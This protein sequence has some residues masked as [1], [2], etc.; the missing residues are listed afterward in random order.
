MELLLQRPAAGI[1]LEYIG[2]ALVGALRRDDQSGAGVHQ[3]V[4]VRVRV[5]HAVTARQQPLLFRP[6]VVE[7]VDEV[8]KM[9][10]SY[11]CTEKLKNPQKREN[12]N[13]PVVE[14]MANTYAASRVGTDYEADYQNKSGEEA[15]MKILSLTCFVDVDDTDGHGFRVNGHVRAEQ[16]RAQRLVNELQGQREVERV[17]QA[18]SSSMYAWALVEYFRSAV[19]LWRFLPSGS[20]RRWRPPAWLVATRFPLSLQR[21][22]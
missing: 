4:R 2:T 5:G 15:V 10:S 20:P 1:G 18:G 11:W 14:L 19:P 8:D 6:A 21:K 17:M 13:L 12:A 9:L 22:V 7:S 3:H 16:A